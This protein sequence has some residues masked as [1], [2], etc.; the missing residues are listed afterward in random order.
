MAALHLHHNEF[1]LVSCEEKIQILLTTDL[2][3]KANIE[4][5]AHRIPGFYLWLSV[6]LFVFP[7]L[8]IQMKIVK[9]KEDHLRDM[10]LV[11]QI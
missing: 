10:H 6:V 11:F 3:S 8:A 4:V 5:P 9:I 7:W 2:K 1:M